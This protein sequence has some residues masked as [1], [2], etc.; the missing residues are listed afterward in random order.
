[1]TNGAFTVYDYNSGFLLSQTTLD[2]FWTTK[3]GLTLT[4]DAVD[5]RIIFDPLLQRFFAVAINPVGGAN[6]NVLFAVSATSDALGSWS[7]FTLPVDPTAKQFSAV[8]VALGM[9]ANAIYITADLV[10]PIFGNTSETGFSIPISNFNNGGAST[11]NFTQYFNIPSGAELQPE[12][13][14]TLNA[15][16]PEFLLS[17]DSSSP[18]AL[19]SFIIAGA[20]NPNSAI[21]PPIDVPVTPPITDPNPA[22]QEGSSTPIFDGPAGFSGSIDQSLNNIWAV[23]TVADPLTGNSEIRWFEFTASNDQLVQS[24]VISDPSMNYY[25]ASVA[26]AT[27]PGVG[28]Q[29]VIG[30]TGSDQNH[31]ASAYAAI[32]ETTGP[33]S[34]QVTTFSTPIL[35]VQ[36]AGSYDVPVNG[37]NAWGNY[38]STVIDPNFERFG[39]SPDKRVL[40]LPGIRLGAQRVER[41]NRQDRGQRSSRRRR[42]RVSLTASPPVPL[43]EGGTGI[44]IT[45]TLS[46]VSTDDVEV[47][48]AF[49]GSATLKITSMSRAPRRSSF[50]PA[51]Q[52]ARS[53]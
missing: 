53:F 17:G 31:F 30:F 13:N 26:V 18:N 28:D 50:P 7:G 10:N 9:D 43:T 23:E 44:T 19:L 46:A 8:G 34:N 6:N 12:T 16:Q 32:G 24:G 14:P 1:M 39:T 47:N 49:T 2:Q 21:S 33:L 41:R 15:S 25:N 36:G 40:D 11:T 51:K 22:P 52:A 37:V 20:A 38:S 29:V 45:A 4:G 35:L 42:C 48:L 27:D 3:A 5:P